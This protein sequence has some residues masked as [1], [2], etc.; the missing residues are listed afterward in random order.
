MAK[1]RLN[2]LG[3]LAGGVTREDAS[4]FSML[5]ESGAKA[6]AAGDKLPA[7]LASID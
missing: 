2:F 3:V 1:C 4:R 5:Q 7:L 6:A